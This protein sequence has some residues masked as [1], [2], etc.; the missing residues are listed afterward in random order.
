MDWSKLLI[1]GASVAAATWALERFGGSPGRGIVS[2]VEAGL[3]PIE[4][5]SG[6]MPGGRRAYDEHGYFDGFG[7]GATLQGGTCSSCY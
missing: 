5:L 2:G 7:P 1:T 4:A 3:E 6:G